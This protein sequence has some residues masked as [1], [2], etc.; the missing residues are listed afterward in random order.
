[1]KKN[2]LMDLIL[3]CA[4]LFIAHE[5]NAVAGDTLEQR[6][7]IS[8][9]DLPE[10]IVE[11]IQEDY[12]DYRITDAVMVTMGDAELD[13]RT[14]G[15]SPGQS[16]EGTEKY[17]QENIQHE[18][19]REG[20]QGHEGRQGAEHLQKEPQDRSTYYDIKIEGPDVKIVRYSEDGDEME[21]DEDENVH[22]LMQ[23]RR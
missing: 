3:V 8:I 10:A 21:F 13:G 23:M 5:I 15:V 19:G 4:M 16:A 22:D 7:P 17:N 12:A 2:I 20:R 1:M 6:T 9:V 18:K 14:E 11:S